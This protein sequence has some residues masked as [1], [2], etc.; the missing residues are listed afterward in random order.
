VEFT[1]PET[2]GG[3]LEAIVRG[4]YAGWEVRHLQFG[5]EAVPPGLIVKFDQFLV[6]FGGD[7]YPCHGAQ[8]IFTVRPESTS[9]FLD[10]PVK[11]VW[12]GESAGEL[13]MKI[14]PSLDIVQLLTEGGI[15]WVLD[16]RN[17]TKN[18]DFSLRLEAMESDLT[19]PKLSMSLGH[20]RVT[21]ERWTTE[22]MDWPDWEPYYIRHIRAKSTYLRS[23][24]PGVKVRIN[25]NVGSAV[26][27]GQGEFSTSEQGGGNK[28]LTILN[29][30]N[31]TIV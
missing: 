3:L 16:C 4:G 23:V 9:P 25:G 12:E 21:V 27:N 20:N 22:D 17:T 26:T 8:H 19:S 18:G 11:L 14:S 29:L 6:D 24:A 30:Y 1:L 31:G 15:T 13:G 7:A 10:M 5:E 2:G 28:H